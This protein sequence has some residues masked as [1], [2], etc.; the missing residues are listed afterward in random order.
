MGQM[1]KMGIWL[2]ILASLI[3]AAGCGNQ[4]ATSQ[5]K[6]SVSE[7]SKTSRTGKSTTTKKTDKVRSSKKT[8]P[9]DRNKDAALTT[10][11]DQWAPTMGQSYE[12]YDGVH[13]LKTSVGTTYPTDLSQVLVNGSKTT[14]GWSSNGTGNYSYNVVAIYNYDGTEPPLPNHITYFFTFHNGQPV[15]LVDESRDGGPRLIDTQNNDVR[16]NF[17]KIANSRGTVNTTKAPKTVHDVKMVGIML[18][19]KVFPGDDYSKETQL[20]VYR[21]GGRYQIDT[22]TIVTNVSYTISGNQVD[23]WVRD[24]NSDKPES[25]EPE[26]KK[27]TTLKALTQQYAATASQQQLLHSTAQRLPPIKTYHY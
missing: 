13:P 15:V 12:K 26:I 14:I 18:R 10:F 19:E 24:T 7:K 11:I 22:G 2:A 20:A 16:T 23:Y 1:K 21:Q 4:S 8:T 17:Q 25:E 5:S 3:L 27:A 9:W 6:Q